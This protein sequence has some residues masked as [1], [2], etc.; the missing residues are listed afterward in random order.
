MDLVESLTSL[1]E[2][3]GEVDM[4]LATKGTWRRV[5]RV[6]VEERIVVTEADCVELAIG[7]R[8]TRVQRK[9]Q[10]T[11]HGPFF[12]VTHFSVCGFCN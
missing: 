10:K 1:I 5:T 9:G 6:A 11:R 8:E 2:S 4:T 3:F 12:C 7:E